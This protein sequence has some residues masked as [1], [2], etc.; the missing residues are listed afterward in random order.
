MTKKTKS[1]KLKKMKNLDKLVAMKS[2]TAIIADIANEFEITDDDI[3]QILSTLC[4]SFVISISRSEKD[5]IINAALML[6]AMHDGL[7][8]NEILKHIEKVQQHEANNSEKIH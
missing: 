1:K 4:S 6:K 3:F 2:V 5:L 7:P 8:H